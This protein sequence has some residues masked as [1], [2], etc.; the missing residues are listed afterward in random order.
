MSVGAAGRI[1]LGPGRQA[2]QIM[3]N[4]I[5]DQLGLVVDIEFSHKV[6]L[7]RLDGLNADAEKASDHL[8]GVSVGDHFDDFPLA[9]GQSGSGLLSLLIWRLHTGIR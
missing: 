4:G 6:E 7:V 3:L 8:N 9:R 5:G 1:S 2:H